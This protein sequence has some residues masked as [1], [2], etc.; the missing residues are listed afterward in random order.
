MT[1]LPDIYEMEPDDWF[2][3]VQRRADRLKRQVREA[4]DE[5]ESMQQ[6]RDA[7][8][9]HFEPYLIDP[10]EPFHAEQLLAEIKYGEKLCVGVKSGDWLELTYHD[11][12]Y[13]W[14]EGAE[15]RRGDEPVDRLHDHIARRVVSATNW[16]DEELAR[17]RANEQKRHRQLAEPYLQGLEKGLESDATTA[18]ELRELLHQLIN[19]CLDSEMEVIVADVSPDDHHTHVRLRHDGELFAELVAVDPGETMDLGEL[20]A[21]LDLDENGEYVGVVTDHLHFQWPSLGDNAEPV[22]LR[23]PSEKEEDVATYYRG[24]DWVVRGLSAVL[25]PPEDE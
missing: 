3:E 25:T 20:T 10:D 16:G 21:Q 14:F 11:G 12:E 1:E 6:L 9:H 2:E 19:G 22:T 24:A 18:G 13:W 15:P 5:S 23:L 4:L 8:R 17:H 7:L